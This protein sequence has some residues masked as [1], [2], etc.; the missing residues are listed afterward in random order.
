V[1]A[2]PS[3]RRSRVPSSEEAQEGPAGTAAAAQGQS[4][5]GCKAMS[6]SWP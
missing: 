2:G 6:W 1:T 4:L 5:V 3:L